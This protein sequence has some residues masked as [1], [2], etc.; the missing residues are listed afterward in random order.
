[1]NKE[2]SLQFIANR[3]AKSKLVIVTETSRPLKGET[4]PSMRWQRRLV[5]LDRY[6]AE[7][8]TGIRAL[9]IIEN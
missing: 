7:S 9:T 1:M 5:E 3:Y 8:R 6:H 4:G 2:N